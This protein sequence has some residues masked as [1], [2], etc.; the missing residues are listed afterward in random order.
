MNSEYKR[1]IREA[2]KQKLLTQPEKKCGLCNWFLKYEHA[3][4]QWELKLQGLEAEIRQLKRTLH[5]TLHSRLKVRT[6]AY[7]LQRNR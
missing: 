7:S 2:Y 6:D 3:K 4:E 5:R 1:L